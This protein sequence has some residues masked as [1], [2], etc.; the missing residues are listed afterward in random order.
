MKK[1]IS[2]AGAAFFAVTLCGAE[3]LIKNGDFNGTSIAPWRSPQKRQKAVHFIQDGKLVVTGDSQNPNQNFN[4]LQ[5]LPKLDPNK[6]YLLSGTAS[7]DAVF[8]PGKSCNVYV[9]AV[10]D[11]NA[12]IG[13]YG[14]KIDLNLKSDNKYHYIYTPRPGAAYHQ[15][16][17]MSSKIGDNEYIYIDD[18]SLTEI[19][20]TASNTAGLIK[21]GDFENPDM[22]G[23]KAPQTG[24]NK[25]FFS[26][27]QDAINGNFSLR[28]SGDKSFKQNNFVTLQ[29][30]LGK[31][32]KGQTYTLSAK[33]RSNVA[34]PGGKAVRVQI[35]EVAPDGKTIKYSGNSLNL[36][37]SE[38]SDYTYSF[39]PNEKAVSWTLYISTTRLTKEDCVIID[40]IDLIPAAN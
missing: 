19:G 20:K 7:A 21:N 38:I 36:R 9:R 12:S 33:Y 34:A 1:F 6:S 26:V 30:Q 31:I 40:D 35:R 16:Y 22:S 17:V 4:F 3:N 24:S 18:L 29:Q 2:L 11:K 27:T 14:F 15:L 39:T 8:K 13:Y 10:N 32:R 28:I 37:N 25:D 5:Y 23:W